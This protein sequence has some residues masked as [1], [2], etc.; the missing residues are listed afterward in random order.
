MELKDLVAPNHVAEMRM[1]L[2]KECEHNMVG[3]CNKCGCILIAKTRTAP[4]QC[5]LLKWEA[6]KPIDQE[7][8]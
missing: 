6:Y 7:N 3:V 4:A 1:A 5:P 2:C 8:N